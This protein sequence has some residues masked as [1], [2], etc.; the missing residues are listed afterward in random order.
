MVVFSTLRRSKQEL[1]ALERGK[2][3]LGLAPAI[4]FYSQDVQEEKKDEDGSVKD[5]ENY[6]KFDVPLDPADKDSKTYEI[7]V[8]VFRHGTAQETI[9]AD[10]LVLSDHV[11]EAT[12]TQ[13][14]RQRQ[15]Q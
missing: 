5:K 12:R 6:R 8:R 2:A 15:N 9:D 11:V 10:D 4:D 14:F 1:E 3:R 13:S 7:S